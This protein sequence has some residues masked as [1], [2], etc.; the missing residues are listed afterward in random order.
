MAMGAS[1]GV[2]SLSSANAQFGTFRDDF[3]NDANPHA[4]QHDYSTGTVPA[5]G[6]WTGIHNSM[7][8]GGP[9]PPPGGPFVAADFVA[10][11]FNFLGNNKAGKLLIED[12]VLHINTDS[13]LG[14]GWEAGINNAPFLYRE[15]PAEANITATMK[16]DAQNSG[17]WHYAPIIARLK[18]PTGAPNTPVGFGR[19]DSLHPTESFVTIGSFRTAADN[20]VATILTQSIVNAVETEV[21]TGG[22][23]EMACRCGY[24]WSRTAPCL[25]PTRRSTVSISRCAIRL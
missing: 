4:A 10:D 15:V 17:Q 24:G 7:N 19:G 21:N 8:G 3:G 6:I 22:R 16:I 13:S 12:L 18:A 5:G 23:S 9:S 20:N 11:G 25:R 1:L 2:L 14:V